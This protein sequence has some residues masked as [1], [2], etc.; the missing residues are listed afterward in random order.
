MA[1]NCCNKVKREMKA[2]DLFGIPVTLTYKGED[3]FNTLVGGIIS[4]LL[5]LIL[6]TGFIER[7]LE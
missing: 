7:L 6:T 4:I 1:G 5:V 2:Q 3:S